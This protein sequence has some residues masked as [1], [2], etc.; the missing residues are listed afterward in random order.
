MLL[1]LADC[2]RGVEAGAVSGEKADSAGGCGC[3]PLAASDDIDT[4]ANADCA[5][6]TSTAA[7][8]VQARFSYLTCNQLMTAP[9]TAVMTDRLEWSFGPSYPTG[10]LGRESFHLPFTSPSTTS[11]PRPTWAAE[12]G[13][14]VRVAAGGPNGGAELPA[15]ALARGVPAVGR[16]AA[17]PD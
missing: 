13:V 5:A 7:T 15:Q 10:D 8:Q 17:P 9:R 14:A 11:A 1:L 16:R 2:N 6:A 12:S 3:I 4:F